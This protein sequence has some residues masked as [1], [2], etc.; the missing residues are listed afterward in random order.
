[1]CG[2][3]V[4]AEIVEALAEAETQRKLPEGRGMHHKYDMR[5]L[6]IRIVVFLWYAIIAPDDVHAAGLL[7]SLKFF[8]HS[9]CVS[10]SS[11]VYLYIEQI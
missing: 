2:K 10:C 4:A 1:M 5:M 7:V 3:G 8:F 11:P 6:R 9:H